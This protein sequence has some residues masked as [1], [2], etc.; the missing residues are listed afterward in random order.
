MRSTGRSNLRKQRRSGFT[1]FE[2]LLATVI[3]GLSIA[4]VTQI[5]FNGA[6][7]GTRARQEAMADLL[8]ES[9]L[10]EW[11][12]EGGQGQTSSAGEFRHDRQ[13]SWTVRQTPAADASLM[14][15]TVTVQHN[16]P[17][18]VMRTLPQ[19]VRRSRLQPGRM[20]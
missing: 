6:Q 17:G 5:V 1:L 18:G 4:G 7:A 8:C 11:L 9:K 10:D 2:V 15:V 3:L 14:L 20:R 13:W 19:L 16:S 12:A